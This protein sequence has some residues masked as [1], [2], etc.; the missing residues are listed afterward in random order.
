MRQYSLGFRKDTRMFVYFWKC[1]AI[2]LAYI[3]ENLYI[4]LFTIDFQRIKSMS[5][6]T[7]TWFSSRILRIPIPVLEKL[8]YYSCFCTKYGWTNFSLLRP[9]W[10]AASRSATQEFPSILWN[11]KVHYHVHQSRSL[12]PSLNQMNPVHTTPSCFSKIHKN[13][14]CIYDM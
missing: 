11:P 13:L 6:Q 4:F 14:G 8:E 9:S 1:V 7:L 3:V 2:S 12:V 5:A 10:E